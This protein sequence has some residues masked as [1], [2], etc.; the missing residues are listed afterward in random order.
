MGGNEIQKQQVTKRGERTVGLAF[1]RLFV[2]WGEGDSEK[3]L[4]I[5]MPILWNVAREGGHNPNIPSIN[6]SAL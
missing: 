2:F 4:Q 6:E 1:V 5:L 3:T